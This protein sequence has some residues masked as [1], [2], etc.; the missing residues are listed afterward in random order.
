MRLIFRQ[1]S[2]HKAK[3]KV[4]PTNDRMR[5]M[6]EVDDVIAELAD[7]EDRNLRMIESFQNS[8]AR[9]S[10]NSRSNHLYDFYGLQ[11]SKLWSKAH[12]G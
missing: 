9:F 2:L 4:S 7:L 5:P 6:I 10:Y 8:Q 1:K 12:F 11:W 3:N